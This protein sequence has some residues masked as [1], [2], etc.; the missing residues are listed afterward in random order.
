[1]VVRST[2]IWLMRKNSVTPTSEASEVAWIS[3]VNSPVIGGRIGISACG[4]T[5]KRKIS[6]RLRPSAVAL[7][8][9]CAADRR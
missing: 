8:I 5:M 6:Q 4:S 7:T 2:T 1:M 9:W 3:V